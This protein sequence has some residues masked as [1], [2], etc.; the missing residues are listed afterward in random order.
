MKLHEL[1]GIKSDRARKLAM[2]APMPWDTS[3]VEYMEEKGFEYIGMGSQSRLFA[4]KTNPNLVVKI[5]LASDTPFQYFLN[6]CQT[7]KSPCLPKFRGNSVKIN[8][9][10]RMVRAEELTPLTSQEW[11]RI[12]PLLFMYHDI[13][14]PKIDKFIEKNPDLKN[15]LMTFRGLIDYANKNDSIGFDLHE[16]NYMK[17]GNEFVI[18]DPFLQRGSS[19]D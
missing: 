8:K 17:R 6:Y 14:N 16:K 2:V 4:Y 3:I 15:L 9:D 1:Y 5:F 19:S 13:N 11:R 10:Y 7:H 18:N 12:A